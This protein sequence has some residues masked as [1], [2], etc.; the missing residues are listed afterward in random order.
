MKK[1]ALTATLILIIISASAQGEKWSIERCIYWAIDNNIQVKQGLVSVET[2]RLNREQAKFDYLPSLSAGGGY[3]LSFGRSLDQTTYQYVNNAS[4]NSVNGSLSLGTQLFAG[5]NKMHSLR[6]SGFNLLA[7]VA[8]VERIRNDI[9]LSVTAAYLQILYSKEQVQNSE[10]QIEIIKQQVDR[11]SKLV[12]AGSSPRSTLLEVQAQLA[13]EEYN[14]VTYQNTLTNNTLTLTQLLELRTIPQGFDIVIPDMSSLI[15]EASIS[16]VDSIYDRALVLPQI[17]VAKLRMEASKSDVSIARARLYPTLNLGV[18]YGSSFSDVRTKPQF[19]PDGT[20]TYGK[21]PFWEQFSDN[22]SSAIQLS[23]QVPIFN[24]LSARRGVAIA[25]QNLKN[26][27]YS[28]T[29]AEDRLYKDIQQ[30][31]TDATGAKNR[32]QSAIHSV[33]SNNETFNDISNKFTVGAATAL[34]Y[35]TAKNNLI[36]AE[37]MLIQAKY[38]YVFRVKLLDFY[39]GIAITL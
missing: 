1:F 20:T 14:L 9:T 15:G 23:I 16:S 35:N 39:R 27:E 6:K 7:A 8:D 34:D 30:A 26:S 21:Y 33:T 31:Y 24:A 36:N 11:T 28:V 22:A 38:E 17:E 18:N 10:N 32:Y 5:M 12:A 2:N 3:N 13:A 4:V 29:L 25:R 37:S 19:A